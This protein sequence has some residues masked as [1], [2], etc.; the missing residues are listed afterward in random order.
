MSDAV[1]DRSM[2]TTV[3]LV[4]DQQLVRAGFGL[5]LDSQDDIEV[6]WHAENGKEAC[7][8]G[9]AQ[10]VDVILMD[11][12]MPVLDGISATE[13]LVEL[14]PVGP[15][16]EVTRIVMLTTFDTDNYVLKSVEAGAS[17]FL[18]KDADPEELI[19]AVRTVGESVGV[20]SPKATARLLRQVRD[21]GH[22]DG[23][24]EA[25]QGTSVRGAAGAVHTADSISLPDPNSDLGLPDPL[26]PREK[27]ILVL[28]ARG[29]S[30][31]EI[32][33]ELYISLPTV[34]TH[35]GRVLLKT[36]SRDRVHAV[37]FAFKN[38]L[39]DQQTLLAGDSG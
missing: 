39:V 37:L 13:Q 8:L 12:Q 34:K 3:G 18:L 30:N 29:Y 2:T 14:A 7:E 19:S 5:V 24:S 4:D 17:G 32:A 15:A 11:V 35:V 27:E 1:T 26:T 21:K 22:L 16:G 6:R 23:R 10:P 33:E 31:Q 9:Q 25:Q 38:G 28:M 36:D 20:I